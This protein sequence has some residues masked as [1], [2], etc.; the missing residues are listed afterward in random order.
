VYYNFVDF[1]VIMRIPFL[2]PFLPAK[3]V[4]ARVFNICFPEFANFSHIIKFK[5]Y[6]WFDVLFLKKKITD[7]SLPLEILIHVFSL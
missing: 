4:L 7:Q 2:F 6:K 3:G 5:W 1:A